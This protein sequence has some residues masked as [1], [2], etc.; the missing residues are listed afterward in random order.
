MKLKRIGFIIGGIGSCAIG[1]DIWLNQEGVL[2]QQP[3]NKIAGI[4]LI[5]FGFI[6]VATGLFKPKSFKKEEYIC[7]NCEEI[8]TLSDK[9]RMICSNCKVEMEPLKGFYERHLDKL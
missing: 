2:Y 1:L 7:K 8:I 6:M 9:S 3:V 4:P 5:I